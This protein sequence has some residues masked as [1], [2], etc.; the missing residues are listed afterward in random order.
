M[1]AG[2]RQSVDTIPGINK[3]LKE[4]SHMGRPTGITVLA[5][6]YFVGAAFCVLGGIG[7]LA[8]GGMMAGI[9]KQNPG[10]DAGVAGILMGLGAVF[11]VIILTFGALYVLLG[12]GLLKLKDWARIITIVLL[13][14]GIAS[15]LFGLV[16]TLAHFS[17]F[18]LVWTV[19]WIAVYGL[20][21]W[22][23]VKP[24]VKAAF[25]GRAGAAAA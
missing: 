5:V 2:I 3:N 14:L 8:G 13:A 15:S 4:A 10:S 21:I 25:Q 19:F 23:L 11:G 20:I 6:L 12:W 24:E 9:L 7:M 1:A 16:T 18:S 17:I 22:Y